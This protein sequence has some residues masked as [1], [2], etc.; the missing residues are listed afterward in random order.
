MREPGAVVKKPGYSRLNNFADLDKAFEEIYCVCCLVFA[1][2][3]NRRS[4]MLETVP[5]LR[6]QIAR[7]SWAGV[8]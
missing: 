8:D 5:F 6:G 3:R 1:A 7:P 4:K 2:S